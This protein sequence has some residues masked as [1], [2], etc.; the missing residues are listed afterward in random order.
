MT[1]LERCLVVGLGV[2]GDAVTAALVRRGHS[3]V[4]VEDHPSPAKLARA[5]SLG[6]ELVEAPS[7]EMLGRLV[8]SSTAVLPSPGVPEAHSVFTAAARAGVGVLSE[9]DLARMWDTRPIVAI[10]GTNGKTT[11]TTMVTEMIQAGGRSCRS[12]GNTE[13]PLVEAIEDAGVDIFVVEASSFRLGHTQRFEPEV[14][15]WLN[16]AEDHLDAHRSLAA[17]E[18]AKARIWADLPPG[19]TRV[20][21][22]D[23]PVVM[24]NVPPGDRTVTFGVSEKADFGV[25][26][27]WLSAPGGVDL[28]RLDEL[29]R[30]LPH[31]V[32][33]SLAAAAT[34]FSAG[35]S[36]EPVRSVLGTFEGLAHRVQL[37]AEAS[38]IRWFDDSKATAPHATCA[39][40]RGFDS[41]VLIAGGRNKGLDLGSLADE[42]DRVRAVVAIGDAAT[43]VKR[44]FE[45]SRTVV[46]A[47][48]M[49]EAVSEAA[50]L[51]SPGDAVLLS[52]GCASFDWYESYSERG[53]AFCSAVRAHLGGVKSEA[54]P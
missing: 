8:G 12:A 7:P 4:V 18:Q 20:A 10:T 51:A 48:S 1:S 39:A 19:G 38:G 24:R 2:T 3:V 29:V 42:I 37:V 35:V 31:D 13:V 49:P 26:H 23:D 47:A 50:E 5:E 52:P 28:L 9:L 21:N 16:F 44:V 25:R 14:A 15:T 45:G 11:V 40:L 32:S 27:G 6:V 54:G 46:V 34:A 41:V 33:N 17:Y 36:I 30:Q 43:E 22:A 53:D